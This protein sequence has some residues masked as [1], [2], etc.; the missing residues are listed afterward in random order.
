[1]NTDKANARL[2]GVLAVALTALAGI[3]LRD[4]YLLQYE[5]HAA[6]LYPYVLDSAYYDAWAQRV[7]DG[8]G[9]GPKPFYMAPLYPY[10]LASVYKVMGHKPAVVYALQAILGMYSVLLVYLLGRRLFGHISGLAAMGLIVLYAPLMYLESKILTETLAVALNLTSFLLLIRAVERPTASRYL[11]AGIAL[12]L[13]AVCRPVALITIAMVVPWLVFGSLRRWSGFRSRS[14]APLILGVA[15]A[16]LPVTARNYFV[17]KDFAFIS[18]NGGIVFAQGNHQSSQ[19][20]FV[21]L[22]GFSGTVMT[23]QEEEMAIAA[24]ALGHPVKPSESSSYWFGQGL[25]FIHEHPGD[26][27]QLLG[28]KAIWSLHNREAPC[29]YNVYL[30]RTIIP[31]L[32]YLPL[33][34]SLLAGLALFGFI[35]GRREEVKLKCDLLALF[36]LSTFLSLIIFVVS[37]RFR[38]PAAPLLAVFAGFGL[39]QAVDAVRTRSS[40]TAALMGACLILALL[41]SLVP[42]PTPP[43]TVEALGNLGATYL[44]IGEADKAMAMAEKALDVDPDSAQAHNVLG[45]A[46]QT[47]GKLD[48]AIQEY[49]EAIR[50]KPDFVDA[51]ANLALIFYLK[52]EYAEAWNEV[53]LSLRYGAEAHPGFLK[54]LSQKMPDPG[55]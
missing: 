18:T 10:A 26:Y 20:L 23:Q 49:Q 45:G 22:P 31:I 34:F 15:L 41:P 11:L 47:K 48:Q 27:L 53:H 25:R 5:Q 21:A 42:Y 14:L 3:I 46:L 38:V 4:I 16:V 30:E 13:S 9:Y 32:R 54:A 37:S 44:T 35:R 39:V 36:I 24:K 2:C 8:G 52:R 55:E 40:R 29:N 7:A 50:I 17:G 43:I 6:Y 51:H 33:P 19:G 28:R 1:M 12:G